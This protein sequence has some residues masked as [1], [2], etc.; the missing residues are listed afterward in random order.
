MGLLWMRGRESRSKLGG[1]HGIRMKLMTQLQA[2]VPHPLADE[3]PCLLTTRSMT[4]PAIGVL[5]VVFISQSCFKSP[6]MQI[7]RHDI[8]GGKRALRQIR[9]E[10][11]IDHARAGHANPTL[12]SRGRM[13]RHN[14]PVPHAFWPYR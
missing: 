10:Q 9:Q 2:E 11:L 13:G 12:G 3:L 4:T 5:L 8:T 14:D 6:T 1:T 7:Q